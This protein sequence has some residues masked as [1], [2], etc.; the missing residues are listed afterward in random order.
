MV[1]F[2]TEQYR[3]QILKKLADEAK[4]G[5]APQGLKQREA[6]EIEEEKKRSEVEHRGLEQTNTN[7][8]REIVFLKQERDKVEITINLLQKDIEEQKS[9]FTKKQSK[10]TELQQKV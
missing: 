9:V 5:Q 10:L 1:E 6:S 2:K 7:L 8:K 3:Q 4:K